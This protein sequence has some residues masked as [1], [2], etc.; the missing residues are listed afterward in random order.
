MQLSRKLVLDGIRPSL[1][2]KKHGGV[3]VV[4]HSHEAVCGNEEKELMDVAN[5]EG[6]NGR[7][8]LV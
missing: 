5:V 1:V 7:I 8:K 4:H 6:S 3:N 2:L